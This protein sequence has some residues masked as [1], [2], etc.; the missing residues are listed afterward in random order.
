LLIIKTLRTVSFFF[1]LMMLC[2]PARYIPRHS[3]WTYE[4]IVI[5]FIIL[6]AIKIRW[7]YR[8]QSAT[9][10]FVAYTSLPF[11]WTLL[12][13]IRGGQ[14]FHDLVTCSLL[15]FILTITFFLPLVLVLEYRLSKRLN[16]PS[17]H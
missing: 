9:G 13:I 7:I 8:Y 3:I 14:L 17:L 4:L 12:G 11:L 15:M 10:A 5:S 2:A 16:S 6:S 1:Y